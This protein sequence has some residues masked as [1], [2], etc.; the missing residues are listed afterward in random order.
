MFVVL[1]GWLVRQALRHLLGSGTLAQV[2]P[3]FQP[4]ELALVWIRWGPHLHNETNTHHI[5]LVMSKRAHA[6]N[7]HWTARL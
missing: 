6:S 4:H 2:R 3:L 1:D 5:E 7:Q